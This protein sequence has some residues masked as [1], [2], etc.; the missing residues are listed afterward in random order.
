[1]ENFPCPIV[2]PTLDWFGVPQ[3]LLDLCIPVLKRGNY[4]VLLAKK[5]LIQDIEKN[6]TFQSLPNHVKKRWILQYLKMFNF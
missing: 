5:E 3:D 4:A 1:M 6:D 2:P